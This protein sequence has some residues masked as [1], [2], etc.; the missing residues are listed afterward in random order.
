M[1]EPGRGLPVEGVF[2]AAVGNAVAA[3][4]GTRMIFLQHAPL[5][6][7]ITALTMLCSA[8]ALLTTAVTLG[9]YEC[10]FYRKTMYVQLETL[11]TI[12]A[13]HSAAALAFANA[14][15]AGRALM[16]LDAEPAVTAAAL[17][18]AKGSKFA[19][20]RRVGVTT[21][22]PGTAPPDGEVK[23]GALLDLA[24]PVSEAKRFGT[25]LVRADLSAIG[26]RFTAYAIALFGT[27]T[28]S[29]ML[30]FI[31]SGWLSRRIVYPVQALTACA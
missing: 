5:R 31:L 6:R 22:I 18:D 26:E 1:F 4:R 25:L 14:E 28:V 17:Y 13:R 30:A 15:D 23:S 19:E 20:Y 16:A 12:T 29:G 11:S 3:M 21:A 8:V 10:V 27:T 24:V 2:P 7:K 9:V